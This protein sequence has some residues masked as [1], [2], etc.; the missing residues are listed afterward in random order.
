MRP[1]TMYAFVAVGRRPGM[2]M[3]QMC[4]DRKMD[5]FGSVIEMGS[6]S[7]V[8]LRTCAPSMI[9]WLLAPES[10]RANSMG[11]EWVVS[12]VCMLADMAR[13]DVVVQAVSVAMSLASGRYL[14]CVVMGG[15]VGSSRM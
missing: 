1:G 14:L 4:V 5:P 15:E 13:G 8:L 6:G 3:W 7:G 11:R 2:S 12:W 9:K 10:L